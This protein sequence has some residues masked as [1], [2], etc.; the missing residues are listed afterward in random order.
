MEDLHEYFSVESIKKLRVLSEDL[1][2]RKIERAFEAVR[3]NTREISTDR[4][5]AAYDKMYEDFQRRRELFVEKEDA[6]DFDFVSLI[7]GKS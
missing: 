6:E 4:L 5:F 1:R 7:A 3:A 2:N